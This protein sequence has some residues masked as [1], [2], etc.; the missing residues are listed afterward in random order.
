MARPS[1]LKRGRDPRYSRL[2]D[3]ATPAAWLVLLRRPEP[4][5]T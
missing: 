1:H 5:F 4:T 2:Y 3:F